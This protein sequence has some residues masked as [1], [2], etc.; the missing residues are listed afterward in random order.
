MSFHICFNVLGFYKPFRILHTLRTTA[1]KDTSFDFTPNKVNSNRCENGL[2]KRYYHV[3]GCQE[4]SYEHCR[5]IGGVWFGKQQSLRCSI[6]RPE[7]K[8]I[9][10]L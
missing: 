1:T 8:Q 6:K 10:A 3:Q 9:F 2:H 5:D 4:G 7:Q